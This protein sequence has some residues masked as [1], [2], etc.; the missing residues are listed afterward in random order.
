MDE[1]FYR[2]VRAAAVA[3]WW[4]LLVAVVV[5]TGLWGAFLGI[6]HWRPACVTSMWGGV[7]W[8]AMLTVVL[9]MIAVFKMLI[10][11]MFLAV[12][13]LSIWARRLRRL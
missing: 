5:A 3:G 11:V 6:Y 12:V 10:W 2:K 8:E 13:W 7:S 1:L 4:T 9:W